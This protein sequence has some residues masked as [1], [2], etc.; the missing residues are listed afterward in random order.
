GAEARP[1]RAR[2][3]RL[4][5]RRSEA[6]RAAARRSQARRVRAPGGAQLGGALVPSQRPVDGGRRR[7]APPR[8]PARRAAGGFGVA[9]HRRVQKMNELIPL[10]ERAL[11]E[12]LRLT[13]SVN[14][15]ERDLVFDGYKTL[16]E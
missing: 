11:R 8:P 3:A 12:K 14:G 6:G 10:Q 4:D 13:L 1:L 9:T 15:E 16:L 7:Q 5:C 2:G